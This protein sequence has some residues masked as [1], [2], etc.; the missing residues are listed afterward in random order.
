MSAIYAKIS[1]MKIKFLGTS[2]GWPLPRLGCQC[3]VC[4]SKDPKDTRLRP[5]LL[6]NDHILIDA[7]PDIYHQLKKFSILKFTDIVL[8]HGHPDHILG[9]HDLAKSK[10][11]QIKKAINLWLSKATLKIL[12]KTF[13]ALDFNFKEIKPDTKFRINKVNFLPVSLVHSQKF[14]AL[15]LLIQEKKKKMAYFP[16]VRVVSL[17]VQKK[18]RNFDLLIIDGSSF[19]Y[20][21]PS[22]TKKWGHL[23]I[24]DAVK[25][26]KRL[27]IKQLY[28][29]HIG[30]RVGPHEKIDKYLQRR[31]K[32][33]HLAYDGLTR[34][35]N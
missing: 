28:F 29:T 8:T 20:P 23:S 31:N 35:V 1:L 24:L 22:W 25:V 17:I 19:K 27:K 9:L 26:A 15:G 2:S 34:V 18:L 12:R 30:H 10:L 33:Y 32:N 5:A 4:T 21:Y 11:P 14:P 7:G 3:K 6:L 16:D 13:T